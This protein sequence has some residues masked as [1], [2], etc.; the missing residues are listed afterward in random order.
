MN[1]TAAGAVDREL[2]YIELGDRSLPPTTPTTATTTNNNNNDN[3]QWHV[4]VSQQ[5]MGAD[6]RARGRVRAR[7]RLSLIHISEPTRRS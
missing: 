7:G 5:N 1:I 4:C 2:L 6:G 3:H